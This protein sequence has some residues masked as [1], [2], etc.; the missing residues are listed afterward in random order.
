MTTFAV[1]GVVVDAPAGACHVWLPGSDA[2]YSVDDWVLLEW[3]CSSDD[4]SGRHRVVCRV[5][6]WSPRVA[7]VY[8]TVVSPAACSE[9]PQGVYVSQ[10]ACPLHVSI[11]SAH[12]IL[13]GWRVEVVQHHAFTATTALPRAASVE[14]HAIVDSHRVSACLALYSPVHALI[15]C[16]PCG[17]CFAGFCLL[18]R[19]RCMHWALL[20]DSL[21]PR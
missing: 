9:A 15:Q 19:L 16:L 3:K 7:A 6:R 5:R 18:C 21:P 1:A 14:C 13:S 17:V 11:G 8:T 10:A 4:S 20:W 12:D 2:K